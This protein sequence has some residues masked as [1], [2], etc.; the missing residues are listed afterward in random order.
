[1][2]TSRPARPTSR[3]RQFAPVSGDAQ[4]RQIIQSAQRAADQ[5]RDRSVVTVDL[6]VGDNVI[7]HGLGRKPS[8]ATVTPTVANAA[9]AWSLK[10]A[11][12]SQMTLTCIGVAQPGATVEAF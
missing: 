5:L 7:N 1:M 8:G 9:W 2:P 3:P 10:S 12:G 6:I 4:T 11:T